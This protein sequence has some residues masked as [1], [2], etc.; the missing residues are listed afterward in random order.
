MDAKLPA[1]Y[2]ALVATG[3][4]LVHYKA[5]STMDSAPEVGSLGRALEL[6]LAATGE[7][8]API[9][10]ASP[11]MGRFQAFGTLFAVG[12]GGIHRID[13]HPVM[14]RH[15]VTPIEEADICCHLARQTDLPLAA[16]MRPNLASAGFEALAARGARGV[17]VDCAG[18]DDLPP[19]AASSGAAASSWARRG[20]SPPSSPTFRAEG[21]APAEAPPRPLP[22]GGADRRRR[23]LRL[24]RH[25]PPDR[26][27]RGAGLARDPPRHRRP[28]RPG[29]EAAS[30]SDQGAALAAVSAG[31]NPIVAALRGP[32]IRRSRD[33]RRHGPGRCPAR[34]R[35]GAHRRGA[36]PGPRRARS[37]RCAP[38]ARRRGRYFGPVVRPSDSPRCSPAPGSRMAPRS[39]GVT[40]PMEATSR[41][42]SR[43]P[44]GPRGPVR[45]RPGARAETGRA[46]ALPQQPS[47]TN[48]T[49]RT[50]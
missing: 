23:G 34:R 43:R 49:G 50:P 22:R 46:N 29:A 47:G 36:G 16:L 5:C 14:A 39:S 20:S 26:L 18:E 7:A 25:R 37:P 41:S 15:P 32:T 21:L 24:R 33:P 27:G 10:F 17:A 8:C 9:L 38:G 6:G 4:P 35:R 45:T 30:S 13:R 31:R 3:A 19:W 40:E 28:V 2:E 12:P 1:L 48:S 44:D 11:E 42:S